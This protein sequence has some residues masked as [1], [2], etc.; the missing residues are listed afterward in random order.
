M[1]HSSKVQVLAVVLSVCF[2]SLAVHAQDGGGPAEAGLA[3]PP[4]LLWEGFETANW[5][6]TWPRRQWQA[7]GPN[8]V[9]T[10]VFSGAAA[11]VFNCRAGNNFPDDGIGE[12]APLAFQS[13]GTGIDETFMRFYI[14]LESGFQVGSQ[15]KLVGMYADTNRDVPT[16]RSGIRPTGT[17]YARAMLALGANSTDLHLYVY[18]MDQA[19]SYGDR[20][21]TTGNVSPGTWHALELGVKLNTPGASDGRV[22]A[23]LDGVAVGGRSDLR[24]RT[25]DTLKIHTYTL[26]CYHGGN[27]PFPRDERVFMDNVVVSAAYI[28]PS[29]A[30]GAGG[31]NLGGLGLPGGTTPTTGGT[32][33]PWGGTTGTTTGTTTTAPT[34]QIL[35]DPFWVNTSNVPYTRT[36]GSGSGEGEEGCG[37]TGMECLLALGAGWTA[38]I[39]RRL[40]G[41]R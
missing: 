23:W 25:A 12:Y 13:P 40:R 36:G 2:C 5:R 19:G 20:I 4:V 22:G 27:D 33:N 21:S 41:V 8:T 30:A 10:P 32:T 14:Y 38:R 11:L 9:G 39:R 18:H 3:A 17:N 6:D 16:G 29:G 1:N 24:F 7:P 35:T 37:A 26:E 31:G 15:L 28:G 34:G